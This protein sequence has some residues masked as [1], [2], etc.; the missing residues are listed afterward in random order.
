VRKTV[1]RSY[2]ISDFAAFLRKYGDS[3]QQ[4][5]DLTE[6]SLRD[7][8][9]RA[10]LDRE[11]QQ[12]SSQ[13]HNGYGRSRTIY[14][15]RGRECSLRESE[16]QTLTD[17]GKFRIVPADDLA[18]LGY[19]GDGS[20]MESDLRHLTREGLIEE[21]HIEGHPSYSTR[22]LTLTR[23]GH[24]LLG[25]ANLVSNRQALY[26]GLVKIKEA[27]HDAD[28][29]RLYHKVAREIHYSGGKVRRVILDYQL[30]R[31]LYRKLSR[32]D[33]D[34][35]L[36]YERIRVANE[37]DL[38]V[39][40]GKIPVPDLRI[41]Y[42]DDC[43]EIRRLDLEIVTRDYRPQGLAEKAK[44]GFHMF[45]RQQD[46]AKLRRVLDTQEISARIFAL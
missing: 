3:G 12:H 42:E 32:V 38:K 9:H 6:D 44:A 23:H 4:R 19:R 7:G 34:K 10:G 31:E 11:R 26:H 30:K 25:R 29:Y 13:S 40:N 33:P 39:V 36:A 21:R 28:L 5:V 14:R 35:E 46:H 20:R 1:S 41:E 15:N 27:R 2:D 37:Y 45:A 18:R 43:R 22:V 8:S 24:E 17:L 16:V